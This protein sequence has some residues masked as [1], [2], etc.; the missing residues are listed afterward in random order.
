MGVNLERRATGEGNFLL[1]CLAA[2]HVYWVIVNYL[3]KT[4]SH[5]MNFFMHLRKKISWGKNL[6]VFAAFG[7]NIQQ[8]LPPLHVLFS[9]CS[10]KKQLHNI[11]GRQ[12]HMLLFITIL[13]AVN[14]F[15]I[16][17]FWTTMN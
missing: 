10:E 17:L 11:K 9:N 8:L 1:L 13:Y 12:E 6:G 3:K 14:P 4:L 2:D 16:C 15:A 7:L 5:Q